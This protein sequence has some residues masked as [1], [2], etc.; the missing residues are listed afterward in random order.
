MLKQIRLAL[1]LT[2]ETFDNEINAL[3]AACKADLKIAGIVNISNSDPL[4]L[5]A[6]TLYCKGHFGYA[7]IGEKYLQVYESLKT[8]L[9]LAG[10]LTDGDADD[11]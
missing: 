6:V 9:R 8:P 7:D 10:K 2:N 4:A 3:I 5:Q 11:E 1:R